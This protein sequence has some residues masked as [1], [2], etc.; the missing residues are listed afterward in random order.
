M[1]QATT[2]IHMASPGLLERIGNFLM[3]IAESNHRIRRVEYLQSL[4]DEQ[5]AARGI[6][7]D[8]IVHH[9]FSDVMYT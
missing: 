7:R 4:S 9:V 1:A 6:R 8:A 5:L 2:N 3:R